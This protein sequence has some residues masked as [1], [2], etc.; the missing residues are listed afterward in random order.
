MSEVPWYPHAL[1]SVWQ[2]VLRVKYVLEKTITG[3]PRP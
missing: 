2:R 1:P 3:V